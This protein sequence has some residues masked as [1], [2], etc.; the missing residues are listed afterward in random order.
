MAATAGAEPHPP[1]YDQPLTPDAGAKSAQ[2]TRARLAAMTHES[3]TWQDR[4]DAASIPVQAR[5]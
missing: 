1:R 4:V 5:W 2:T 3:G